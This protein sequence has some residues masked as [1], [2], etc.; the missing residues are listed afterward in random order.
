MVLPDPVDA[1]VT[2]APEIGLLNPSSTVTVI[3]DAED[4]LDAVME[5][6]LALTIEFAALTLPTVAVAVNVAGLPDT[7]PDTEAWTVF[8]PGVEPSVQD[9][10]PALPEA[11]V[12]TL[13]PLAGT[14]LPPPPVTVNVTATPATGLPN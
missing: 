11:S 13:F 10:S 1:S 3:V 6:G 9:V 14:V 12:F 7:V 8:V 2:L 4:P 5:P